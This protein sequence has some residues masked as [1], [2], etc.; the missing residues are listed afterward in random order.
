MSR[1][2]ST[3][4]RAAI[5]ARQTAEVFL[6][7]LTLDDGIEIKRV[8]KNTE[9]ITSRGNV[10]M[11]S[12]FGITFPLEDGEQLPQIQLDIMNVS[13]EIG[14]WL[15]ETTV[16]IAVTVEVVLASQPDVVEISYD[17][18]TLTDTKADL[19]NV[20]GTINFDSLYNEPFPAGSFL[21]QDFNGL[22]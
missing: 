4:A 18:M 7:L 8:V 14:I 21:P 19:L 6:V 20:T 10:Y 16:P 12:D 15:E 3:V 13:R 5:N 2:L 17:G 1:N 22:F 11:R 9:D